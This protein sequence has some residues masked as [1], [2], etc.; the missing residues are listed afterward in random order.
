MAK[1]VEFVFTSDKGW[2]GENLS[3]EA[4]GPRDFNGIRRALIQ[5]SRKNRLKAGTENTRQRRLERE[6]EEKKVSEITKTS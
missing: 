5:V 4:I 2:V 3:D 1:K 6:K